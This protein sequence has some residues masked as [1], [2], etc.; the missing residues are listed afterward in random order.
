M[1]ET[2]KH[3]TAR[4]RRMRDKED[5]RAVGMSPR[6]RLARMLW[7]W[8]LD[9][10]LSQ[11]Q[12]ADEAGLSRNYIAMVERGEADNMTISAI[13]AIASVMQQ[14]PVEVFRWATIMETPEPGKWIVV[15][16]EEWIG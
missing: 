8:R 12:V 7:E 14:T 10:E 1:T 5:A 13:C 2:R 11:G 3:Y 4:A 9:H 15:N 6:P 16:D